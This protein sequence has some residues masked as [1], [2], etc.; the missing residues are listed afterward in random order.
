METGTGLAGVV[1][2]NV[3]FSS[4]GDVEGAVDVML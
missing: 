2:V 3:D 1:V 4:N